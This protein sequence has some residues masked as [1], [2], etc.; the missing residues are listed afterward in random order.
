[1]NWKEQMWKAKSS[2]EAIKITESVIE[3]LIEDIS[4]EKITDDIEFD[5]NVLIAEIPPELMNE[6]ENWKKVWNTALK[7]VQ[8]QLNNKWLN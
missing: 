3:K 8:Q 6:A 5:S 7:Y 1:M 4:E 2:E